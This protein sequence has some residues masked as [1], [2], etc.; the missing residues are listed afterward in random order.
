MHVRTILNSLQRHKGFVYGAERLATWDGKR[1]LEIPIRPRKGSRP[2]CSKCERPGPTYDH[3]RAQRRFEHVPLWGM[4]VFF[5]Y[6]M[7]RVDCPRCGVKIEKVPW[8]EGKHSM[9][10]AFQW[11]LATWAKVLSWQ[12][13]ADAFGV[14]WGRVYGS[15]VMAVAWGRARLDLGGVEAIGVDEIHWGRGQQGYVTLVYQIDAG[16]KRLLWMGPRRRART[17]L[18][19]FRWFGRD[20]TQ[21]LRFVCSDMWRPY[22]KVIAKKASHAVHVLDRFHIVAHLNK[23]VDEVRREEAGAMKRKGQE[24]VLAGSRWCL[25]KKRANLTERQRPRLRELLRLN[26]RTVRAYLLKEDFEFFWGYT[27]PAWAGK[28]LDAWC[29][30]AMRSRLKPMKRVAKMLRAHRELTLNWFRARKAISAGVVE[31]MNNKAK[32]GTK[33]AYGFHTY[34]CLETALYHRLGDLPESELAHR[35]S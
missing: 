18:G 15:V 16:R 3:P 30:S 6:T 4:A 19:F 1:C 22:L 23:A 17:L 31:G 28:F 7:R 24:P 32:L 21:R 29:E 5:L 34:N 14:E 13:V 8:C 26:L 35:F 2:I 9:T 11:F 10:L 25:L 27:H 12:Q 20:N 33:Q